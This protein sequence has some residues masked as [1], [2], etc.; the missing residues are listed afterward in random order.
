MKRTKFYLALLIGLVAGPI[1]PAQN[2]LGLWQVSK[3]M[4]G[5]REMTPQEKWIRF[6]EQGFEGGNGLL[7]NGA[8]TYQWDRENLKLSMDDS[9]GFEDPNN[10]FSVE[11]SDS[12]MQWSRE[13]EGMQVNVFLKW[14]SDL[15]LRLADKLV[16]VWEADNQDSLAYVFF[17]WDRVYIAVSKDGKRESGLWYAHAHRPELSLH[18]WDKNKKSRHFKIIAGPW[19]ILQLKATDQSGLEWIF[20]RRRSFPN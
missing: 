16:G 7:Q 6:S 18:P 14:I 15:P 20:S 3:V 17:R 2:I 10:A 12:T 4:V 1:L 11:V 5:D 8:G 19:R 9:L 13:E